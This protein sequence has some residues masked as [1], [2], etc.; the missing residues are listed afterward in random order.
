MGDLCEVGA[1]ERDSRVLAER[2]G[3][4]RLTVASIAVGIALA[5]VPPAIGVGADV[6]I[7]VRGKPLAGTVVATPFVGR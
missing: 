6:A 2:A 7:D 5:F 1:R 3:R 4:A